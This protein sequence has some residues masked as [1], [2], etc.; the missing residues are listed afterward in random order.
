M[1]GLRDYAMLFVYFKTAARCSAV[2]NA[3]IGDIERTDFDWYLI[4]LG[5]MGTQHFCQQAREA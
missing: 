1:T 3:M 5:H 2:R 4:V